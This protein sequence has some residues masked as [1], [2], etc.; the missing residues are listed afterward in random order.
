MR[1]LLALRA[2]AAEVAARA[3]EGQEVEEVEE[4]ARE[5]Q[6]AVAVVM[7]SHH[8]MGQVAE[9]ARQGRL[10]A[11]IVRDVWVARRSARLRPLR[12]H[13]SRPAK[14][15]A[16]SARGGDLVVKAEPKLSP[17]ARVRAR[18]CGALCWNT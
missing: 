12:M 1:G 17:S 11:R 16:R 5:G 4:R 15:T 3:K 13:A 2:A 7:V 6:Q 18:G 14:R 9:A 10:E 8:Q